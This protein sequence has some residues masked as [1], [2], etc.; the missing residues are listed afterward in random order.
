M[1]FEQLCHEGGMNVEWMWDNNK[2][3]Y[4]SNI[5]VTKSAIEVESMC[6]KCKLEV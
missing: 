5:Y 4:Q 1:E 3:I 2:I 6:D